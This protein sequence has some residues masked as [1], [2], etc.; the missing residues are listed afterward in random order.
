MAQFPCDINGVCMACKSQP[1]E[2]EKLRCVTCDTPWH[3]PCLSQSSLPTNLADSNRWLCPDCETPTPTTTTSD[4]PPRPRHQDGDAELVAAMLAIEA[5][6]SLTQQQKAR[7]RQQLITGK[8]AAV[9]SEDDDDDDEDKKKNN[10]N[11][12]VNDILTLTLNCS[13][14]IQLPERPVTVSFSSLSQ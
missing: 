6:T 3:V 9:H 1:A 2:E 12:S 4:P 8:A 11:M 5:D 10:N 7:K 13:I 14:C